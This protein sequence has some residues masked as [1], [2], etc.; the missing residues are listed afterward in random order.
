MKK[1][2]LIAPV[3][4]KGLSF[5]AVLLA[6]PEG[7]RF[8]ATNDSVRIQGAD[9]VTFIVTAATSYVNY[10][11]ISGD[12]AAACEKVL[13][14]SASK[15]YATLRRQHENDFRGL[16]GRVHLNIGD[17]SMN[18]K[19]VDERLKAMRDGND[20]PNLEALTFQFGRYIL[21]SSSRAGGQ[22][23]NLQG[24][25]NEAVIPNWGSKYTINI[26]TEMNY[27]P[28]EVCNLSEC[29][30]PLFDMLKDLS[31][32]GAKTAKTFYGINGWVTHHNTDLWRGAAPTDAARFGMW[33]VGGAWLC[34]HLWEHYTF[35]G[36]LKFLKEY[37][38]VMK[39]AAQFLLELM[40]EDP[41]HHWLVTPFS[42]SPEHGYFDSEGKMAFLSP[43]PTMDV[44]I[45]RE[46]FPHCI[47]A[48]KLLNVDAD[49]RA[50]LE[51]AL[52]KIPPY[53]I[54]QSGFIQEWIEDWKPGPQGH[55]VSPNFPFYPGS[56]ITLRGNPDFAV[57]YQKWMEAHPPRGGFPLSWGIAMWARLEHGDKVGSLVDA[58]MNRAPANN[59]HNAGANQSDASFGYTAAVAEALVQSHAGEISLLPALP[60][61]WPDGSVTGLRARGDYEVSMQ[62]KDGKLTGAEISSVKGG[63]FKVRNGEK[64]ASLTLK[65]GGTILLNAELVSN[66]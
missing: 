1:D 22:P 60:P 59:L 29:H 55:N 15:D 23:A 51:T 26:N 2:W 19:P 42:M 48:S 27:W 35:T 12:P 18:E 45:I 63:D 38:P 9:A 62:W 20:D 13:A 7:G 53:Q 8:E 56:S 50:K 41:K 46:L 3:E 43:S 52:T 40:V 5:Q 16:M 36:D 10:T 47:E 64:T 57:A 61:Q 66:K 44:G 32:T 14:G 30:Q 31:V 65:P 25:W 37:Y 21:A 39:G 11:N 58:Y 34:Q 24:I 4:G 17:S 49:F 54:G 28:A 33:P 6:H